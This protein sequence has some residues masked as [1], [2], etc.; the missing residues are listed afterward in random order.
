MTLEAWLALL[1]TRHPQSIDL[2]LQRCGEVYQ[3]L[4]SPR[5]AQKVFTVAGTNG[6]GST[7]AYLA[8]MSSATGLRFGTY[9]SPHIFRF[10][11]RICVMG[12]TVDDETLVSAFGQ[13]EAARETVSLTYFEFTTLAGL[14]I[15][16]QAELDCVVLEVGLGGRLDT[17]NLVDTDCAVITPIGLDHLDFLGPDLDSIAR[18]KAGII[19]AGTPVVC[20][21]RE[22]PAPVLQT[23]T[24]LKAPV[25]RRGV[26]FDLQKDPSGDKELRFSSAGWSMSV[27]APSLAGD[28]QRD[29]LAAALCAFGTLY[30]DCLDRPGTIA[31]AIQAVSVPGRLQRINSTP[32]ILL[33]VGHNAMAAE[34]VA[35]FLAQQGPGTHTLCV[36]AMLADK[37]AEQVALAMRC[38]CE[39]WICAGLP[40]ERGQAG[41]VL[42]QRVRSVL[43]QADIQTVVTVE[44]AMQ[45]A[46][47]TSGIDRILVFGS[48]VTIASAADWLQKHIQ[49]DL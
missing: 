31:S 23:A 13:V 17:V 46:V 47:A 29:N 24:R 44:D 33:D 21:E 4:G 38:V 43:P 30:P 48:F 12:E 2:G 15:L 14:L 35:A 49:R 28:Y 8:A 27:P 25:Y 22:P 42:A 36:L 34:A 39:H 41:S 32:E 7:V 3:R 16:Q 6:K 40:G 9:T 26:D 20:S 18:E 11:E 10:N 5:P 37:P 45:A 19:R 1:E